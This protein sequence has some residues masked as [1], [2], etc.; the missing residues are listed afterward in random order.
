MVPFSVLMSVYHKESAD[1]LREA[2][3]SLVTQTVP[4]SEVV[5]VHDGALTE[6]LYSCIA[7]FEAQ[8]PL[9][10][11][12]LEVNSGLG[13]ALNEGLKHCSH[14]L[15]MRADTDDINLESRFETQLN[16]MQKNPDISASSGS[17]EEFE[18]SVGDLNQKRTL[19]TEPEDIRRIVR[20]RNPLNH[21]AVVFRKSD[22]LKVGGYRH[23]HFM[24]DYYLWIRML[25]RGMKLAN[26]DQ[27]LVHARVGN[28]MLSRRRGVSY[29]GSEKELY[30][31]LKENDLY[32]PLFSEINF[33]LRS[34][35][36]ILPSTALAVVYRTLFRK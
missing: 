9:K 12:K 18:V 29:I 19:P 24:E 30:K 14:E 17:I 6:Q 3:R 28:G 16:F 20:I 26:I 5:L 4:A 32:K 27:V 7:E 15:V 31:K 21:M 11:I 13:K 34:L 1:S 10:Q 23:L 36:R 2:L 33:F 35:N 22:V 8:L 25:G